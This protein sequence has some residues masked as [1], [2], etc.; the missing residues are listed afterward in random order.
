MVGLIIEIPRNAKF[1]QAGIDGVVWNQEIVAVTH[2]RVDVVHHDE[3]ACAFQLQ[4]GIDVD[5]RV[6]SDFH[7]IVCGLQVELLDGRRVGRGIVF[8]EVAY[9]GSQL[10]GQHLFSYLGQQVKVVV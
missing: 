10:D 8:T 9:I 6:S 4:V 5:Y 7:L 1:Q 3:N 2:A